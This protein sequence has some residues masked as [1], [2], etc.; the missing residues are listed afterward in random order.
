MSDAFSS[1]APGPDATSLR[2]KARMSSTFG[3]IAVVLCLMA[4]CA[5]CMT[6]IAAFPLGLVAVQYGRTVLASH[7][8]E[9]AEVQARHGIATGGAAL[10]Y[11]GLLLGLFLA[12]LLLYAG[13]IA[14]VVASGI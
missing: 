10:A 9:V 2:E 12:Y 14:M 4:P 11:S 5:S 1:P 13:M 3:L 6:L 8:D 7:P